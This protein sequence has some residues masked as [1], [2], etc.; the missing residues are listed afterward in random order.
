MN[1]PWRLPVRLTDDFLQKQVWKK[2]GYYDVEVCELGL[3]R[4]AQY[5]PYAGRITYPPPNKQYPPRFRITVPGAKKRILVDVEKMMREVFGAVNNKHLLTYDYLCK[6]R[7]LCMEY[8]RRSTVKEDESQGPPRQIPTGRRRL[9]AGVNGKTCGAMITNY[10]C[11][12]C[13]V[14]IRGGNVTDEDPPNY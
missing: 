3:L 13:W 9:C 4:R 14:I 1:D 5:S 8:N 7:L 11:P 2:A 6:L 12:A 10:R